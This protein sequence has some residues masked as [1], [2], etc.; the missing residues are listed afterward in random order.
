MLL[1]KKLQPSESYTKTMHRYSLDNAVGR[2]I[3]RGQ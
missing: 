3:V 2:S 1:F